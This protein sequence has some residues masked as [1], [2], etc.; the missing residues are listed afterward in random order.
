M[1]NISRRPK[2]TIFFGKVTAP[3]NPAKD[4]S[5]AAS[6]DITGC[7]SP[8]HTRAVEFC[9]LARIAMA[10][11]LLGPSG[12]LQRVKGNKSTFEISL[13]GITMDAHS[14]PSFSGRGYIV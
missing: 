5:Q 12:E 8:I 2:D 11:N 14:C 4:T 1:E 10:D 9:I 7:D 3:I 13:I 6:T